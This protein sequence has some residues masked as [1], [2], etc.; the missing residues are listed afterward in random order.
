MTEK[1]ELKVGNPP[2]NKAENGPI[3]ATPENLPFLK[4]RFINFFLIPVA[5]MYQNESAPIFY[6]A[7]SKKY[8][9][10]LPK[11]AVLQPPEWIQRKKN[12]LYYI[13]GNSY[14]AIKHIKWGRVNLKVGGGKY[15]PLRCV[16]LGWVRE[17]RGPLPRRRVPQVR[18][19]LRGRPRLPR[20]QPP[21]LGPD[22]QGA[23][24]MDISSFVLD[25]R[26]LQC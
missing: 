7:K 25:H 4:M 20:L 13:F 16:P 24:A 12:T 22:Q 10:K 26:R 6:Y 11:K 14:L 5:Q 8:C 17:W 23:E 2:K 3:W 15:L 21:L 1:I 19:L 18:W 9:L